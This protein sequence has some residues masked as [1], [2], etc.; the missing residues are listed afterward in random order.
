MPAADIANRYRR[1]ALVLCLGLALPWL[2]ACQR[3]PGP[4]P[5]AVD[6]VAQA[7]TRPA[8]AVHV[9]RDRLLA[10]DGAGFA[11]LAVPPALHTQLQAA[12]ARGES[13][14]P[15]DEL[16]LDTHIPRMLVALQAPHADKALMATYRRQFA[17]ADK[18][19]DQAV[20]TLVVFGGEY[21][22]KDAD[23]SEEERA[24]I[25][26]AIQAL[27]DW[28]LAAPL[29]DPKRA[30][31]FFTTLAAAAVRSGLE[32]KAGN[33]AFASLGMTQS[34]NRLSPFFATLLAQLR[35]QYGLDVDAAL[36][37][38]HVSLLQQTGDSAQ[39]RLQ[40]TFA[41]TRIDALAPA[42]RI[43]GHWYLAN[44]VRRAEQSL[45]GPRPAR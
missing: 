26:Q 9:L 2:P 5:A 17:N 11:R 36:R 41:G 23:Y 3:G 8:D 28:A 38:L 15:L 1:C 29:A 45:G 22:R 7:A 6:T 43:D 4:N 37:S 16:P 42:V 32:G 18:D 44:F 21:V 30:R 33:A 25:T 34:L 27:G 31:P 19:I 12:W 40:Y 10:R 13:R 39:L 35:L 14:W 24:H 20:R